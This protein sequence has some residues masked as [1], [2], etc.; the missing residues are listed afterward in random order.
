MKKNSAPMGRNP[1]ETLFEATERSLFRLL[2]WSCPPC[3]VGSRSL[4]TAYFYAVSFR[5]PPIWGK[6]APAT[7]EA[8]AERFPSRREDINFDLLFKGDRISRFGSIKE[9]DLPKFVFLAI[10]RR[11]IWILGEQ[12]RQKIA[13][14]AIFCGGSTIL[15]L[16]LITQGRIFLPCSIEH[17]Q[18]H[19]VVLIQ[20]SPVLRDERSLD[21]PICTRCILE[22]WS[23]LF[24][25]S[26]SVHCCQ[27]R[28][29]A[30]LDNKPV[31]RFRG[32]AE[33]F[34]PGRETLNCVP[35]SPL[36]GRQGDTYGLEN[37]SICHL[38]LYLLGQDLYAS[39]CYTM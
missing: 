9:G 17:C 21:T 24:K 5:L 1:T 2:S 29:S 22:F 19:L 33:A 20:N 3:C 36:E 25:W 7:T 26:G 10:Q 39:S 15:W 31:S 32:K 35:D 37:C 4:L 34:H 6:A 8:V 38:R 16:I 27:N 13:P 11:R 28:L 14:R 30:S 18:R 12:I 23:A